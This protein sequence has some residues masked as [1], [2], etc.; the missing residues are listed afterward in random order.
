MVISLD[1]VVVFNGDHGIY[2]MGFDGIYDISNNCGWKGFM[3]L[4]GSYRGFQFM[5]YDKPQK[6]SRIYWIVQPPN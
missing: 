1:L 3:K 2:I 5:D 6:I 4:A